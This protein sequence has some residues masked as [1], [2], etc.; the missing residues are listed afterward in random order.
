VERGVLQFFYERATPMRRREIANANAARKK[1]AD[2]V[3]DVEA[4]A[5]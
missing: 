2:G 4:P 1:A 3:V 5:T